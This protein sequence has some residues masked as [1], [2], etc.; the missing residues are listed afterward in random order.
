MSLI[1]Y[2]I[3][4]TKLRKMLLRYCG[5]VLC[6]FIYRIEHIA[7]NILGGTSPLLLEILPRCFGVP[8][9]IFASMWVNLG[10]SIWVFF[11]NCEQQ[12]R[13]PAAIWNDQDQDHPHALLAVPVNLHSIYHFNTVLNSCYKKSQTQPNPIKPS[14]NP[15]KKPVKPRK[16]R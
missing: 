9:F 13:Y 1:G 5:A 11:Y 12:A 7:Q 14:K 10:T 3:Q 15:V 8:I 4:A 2:R 16:T 6:C